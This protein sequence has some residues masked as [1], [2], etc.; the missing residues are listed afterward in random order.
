VSNE[1]RARSQ[2]AALELPLAELFPAPNSGPGG[3]P[4]F[5]DVQVDGITAHQL[6]LNPGLQLGYTASGHLV[7]ISTSLRGIAAVAHHSRSLASD[8]AYR[9]EIGTGPRSVTS[10]LF[11]DFSQLLS[12][13]EQTGLMGRGRIRA[14]LP[15]LQKIRT[16]GLSSTSGEADSTAELSLRIS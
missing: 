15:D 9:D 10:V 5:N 14:L 16:I 13:G 1:A 2:L 3:T 6:A 11:L 4:T 12:L 8:P 7:V